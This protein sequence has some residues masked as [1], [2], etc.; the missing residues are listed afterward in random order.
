MLVTLYGF[1]GC[2]TVKKARKWL[3][4]EGIAHDF[5]DYRKEKLDPKTVERW[6]RKAGWETVFNRNSTSFKDLPEAE[7]S[8]IDEK[9]AKEMILAETNLIKRPVLDLGDRVYTG[10]RPEVYSAAF[11]K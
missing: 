5:F 3:E 9:R 7:R 11:D 2:D 8:G 4:A 1:N 10:F 6:F